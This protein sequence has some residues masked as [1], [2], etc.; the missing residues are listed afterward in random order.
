MP[1]EETVDGPISLKDLLLSIIGCPYLL[2]QPLTQELISESKV[3][4]GAYLAREMVLRTGLFI[5]DSQQLVAVRLFLDKHHQELV[6]C[7]QKLQACESKLPVICAKNGYFKQLMVV[8]PEAFT[9]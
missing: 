8:S 5:P 9:V 6:N 2:A 7:I 1:P 3:S 4:L